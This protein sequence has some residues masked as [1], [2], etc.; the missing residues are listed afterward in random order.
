MPLYYDPTYIIL[1]PAILITLIAQARVKSTFN[2]YSTVDDGTGLR[3]E[4]AARRM[5]DANGLENVRINRIS[6]NLTDYYDPRNRTLNLSQSVYGQTNVAA[7]GVACHEAGHAVQHATAYKPLLIRNGIVPAVNICSS[8]S[9]VLIII[10]ILL[11]SVGSGLSGVGGTLIDIGIIAFSAVVLFHLITLPV[12]LNAS[13]RALVAIEENGYVEASEIHGARKV[14]RAAA[15]TYLAALV[16]AL[17]NLLRILA[18]R[19]RR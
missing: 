8:L 10:G 5:L 15:M 13:H 7:V 6:G 16:M 12:E 14:L 3:A 19:N 1:I 4:E 11:L 18:I 2:R 9:W 17:A